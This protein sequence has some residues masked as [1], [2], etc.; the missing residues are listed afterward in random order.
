MQ[1]ARAMHG[2]LRSSMSVRGCNPF[3]QS[4][5]R[6]LG[7]VYQSN[8]RLAFSPEVMKRWFA[9]GP[10]VDEEI[11]RLFGEDIQKVENGELDDWKEHP[12][13]ALASIVIMDQF[14][15]SVY[16]GTSKMCCMDDKCFGLAKHMVDSGITKEL[17]FLERTC[18]YL[19]YMHREDLQAQK[20]CALLY[21]DLL[22]EVAREST[23][24]SNEPLIGALGQS[25]KFAQ[26]HLDV[27]EK[28]GRFP[29]RNVLLGRSNTP[30]EENDFKEG[31]IP[32]F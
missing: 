1:A 4:P 6:W 17:K 22:A 24:K 18:V 10:K 28:Y 3:T 29:H 12:Y 14:V 20:D 15:R 13:N 32:Q 21:K 19:P 27:V 8:D 26:H 31:I 2:L 16:R 9:G 30:Q 11:L 7:D 23:P 5:P 25:V